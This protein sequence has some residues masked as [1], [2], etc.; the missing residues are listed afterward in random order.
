MSKAAGFFLSLM[1][2]VAGGLLLYKLLNNG[3]GQ[4]QSGHETSS[5]DPNWTPQVKPAEYKTGE[6]EP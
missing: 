3:S 6:G 4:S 2:V 5:V 1:L